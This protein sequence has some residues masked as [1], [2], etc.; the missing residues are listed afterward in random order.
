LIA[1]DE[2]RKVAKERGSAVAVAVLPLVR[3]WIRR[4]AASSSVGGGERC[5]WGLQGLKTRWGEK[6]GRKML[7]GTENDWFFG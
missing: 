1:G 4:E 7:A 2:R 3:I 5:L 6:E